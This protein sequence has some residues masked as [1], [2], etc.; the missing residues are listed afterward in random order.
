M[1]YQNVG[2]VV[3]EIMVIDQI[4]W[5]LQQNTRDRPQEG[6]YRDRHRRRVVEIGRALLRRVD[7]NIVVLSKRITVVVLRKI[8]I[9]KT[10]IVAKDVHPGRACWGNR[11]VG[12]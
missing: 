12:L 10:V 4:H 1:G 5:V 8:K 9:R 2:S 11:T 3:D 6:W 7:L